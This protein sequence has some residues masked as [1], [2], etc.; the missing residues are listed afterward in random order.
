[1]TSCCINVVPGQSGLMNGTGIAEMD[2]ELAFLDEVGV[3]REEILCAPPVTSQTWQMAS[4]YIGAVLMLVMAVYGRYG[5]SCICAKLTNSIISGNYFCCVVGC[6][7]I[8]SVCC[9]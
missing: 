2:S 5:N 4:G 6:V 9:G 3:E 1:M 7:I 8:T